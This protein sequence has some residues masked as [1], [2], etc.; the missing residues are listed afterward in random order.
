MSDF[1]EVYT[2]LTDGTT[3]EMD[4]YILQDGFMFLDRK[5]CILWT[6]FLEFFMWE[7]H[8]GGLAGHIGN[9]KTIEAFEYQLYWPSLK[10]D[11]IKYVGRY[12]TCQLA[13]Q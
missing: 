13:K 11:V 1:G 10:R 2:L 7:L 9:E 6:F 8:D 4:G 12:H 5:L 3:R